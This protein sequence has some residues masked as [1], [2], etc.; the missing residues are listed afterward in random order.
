MDTQAESQRPTT[1]SRVRYFDAHNH[2][3]DDWLAP[4][5]EKAIGQLELLP[6]GA[7]VVNGTAED[8]WTR[9]EQLAATHPWVRPSFGLHPWMVGNRSAHWE[10]KLNALLDRH[11]GA[12]LGEIG[13]DRWILERARADDPRLAGLK[14]ASLLEQQ[15]VFE[16]QLNIAS[17]RNLPATIHCIDAWGALW[18]VLSS[19]ELPAPGYLLHAYGGSLEMMHA[20]AERGAY[21]SFN[22]YFLGDRKERQ[23]EVFRAV[24]LHRLLVETDAPSMP[25]PQTWRTHKLPPGPAGTPLNQPG[26]I[27]AVYSGLA[28]LRGISVAELSVIVEENFLRLFGPTRHVRE[29]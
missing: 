18:G 19:S 11:P 2:L 15:E 13:L 6:I 20:F 22:G 9:V 23:Q 14:R 7:A 12:A 10:D 21:F 8:D 5:L 16:R 29:T 27:E 17:R 3:Q 28:T 25:L 26:N 4:H 1:S 24:P